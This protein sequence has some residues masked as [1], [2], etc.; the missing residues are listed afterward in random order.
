MAGLTPLRALRRSSSAGN[1]RK[2]FFLHLPKCAG[3]SLWDV[4]RGLVGD[5]HLYQAYSAERFHQF[6]EM[7]AATRNA[8]RV[9][10]GHFALAGYQAHLDLSQYFAVTTFR[11][12]VE[13][14][15]SEYHYAGNN[16]KHSE[17]D[18]IRKLTLAQFIERNPDPITRLICGR[19]DAAAAFKVVHEVFDRWAFIDD[20]PELVGAVCRHLGKPVPALPHVNIGPRT[21]DGITIEPEERSLIQRLHA[22]DVDLY[23]MLREERDRRT[24]PILHTGAAGC[25]GGGHPDIPD[26]DARP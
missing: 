6:T 1:D 14:V 19:A 23:R 15:V 3:S 24:R 20:L 22:A 25:V 10:G 5:K 16:P 13:R 9:T 4:L 8:F 12:P 2:V 17:Y 18:I 11:E 7:D 26:R 21:R